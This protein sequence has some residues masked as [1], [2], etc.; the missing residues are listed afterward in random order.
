LGLA[1]AVKT[2]EPF[3]QKDPF[4]MYLGDNILKD[5]IVEFA[6]K[7]NRQKPNALILLTPVSNP[8]QFGV[9]ELDKADKVLNLVEKPKHPKSNLALVGV[10]L[11][12]H[13]IFEAVAAIKPSG[14]N[15]LEITDAI[16]WLLDNG[17]KVE[18]H[19]VTGWWKDTGKPSDILEAN[20]LILEAV[21]SRIDG[22]ID[23][24]TEITGRVVIEKGAEV[25]NSTL[26]GPIIIGKGSKVIDSYLGP[27][28][29]VG[30][31]VVIEKSEVEHSIILADCEIKNVHGRIDES[32][33]GRGA[34]ISSR[35]VRPSSHKFV[36]GDRS[37]IVIA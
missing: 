3:L 22:K 34:K 6:E 7:F 20:Q 24:K 12:D 4:I 27:F 1:H 25:S 17:F 5:G 36:L 35:D 23:S 26:R 14:R 2:A 33:I 29:S 28:T 31:N 11:F 9:A 18:S 13:H 8:Q 37:D 30:E 10:Y 32:L 19:K 15:E 21:E 16:Q